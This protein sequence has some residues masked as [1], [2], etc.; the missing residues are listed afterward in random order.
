VLGVPAVL[1][2]QAVR[3]TAMWQAGP[4]FDHQVQFQRRPGHRLVDS[5]VYAWLR[6]PSYFG[7]FYWATGLQVAVGNVL[8]LLVYAATLSWFFSH[9]I[10][11]EEKY[12]VDFFGDEYVKYRQRTRVWIPGVWS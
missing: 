6:H 9:R 12:L 1:L 10:R 8:S 3:S 7:Y 4:N 11:R 2:G 5:G